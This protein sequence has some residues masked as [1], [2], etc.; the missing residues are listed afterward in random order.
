MPI[1]NHPITI[2]LTRGDSIAFPNPSWTVGVNGS[3]WTNNIGAG[4]Y[5]LSSFA[6]IPNILIDPKAFADPTNSNPEIGVSYENIG[7]YASGGVFVKL[8]GSAR[9]YQMDG[10]S[11]AKTFSVLTQLGVFQQYNRGLCGGTGPGFN[12]ILHGQNDGFDPLVPPGA[13]YQP[14]P[15]PG[16]T[17]FEYS[18]VTGNSD[19]GFSRDFYKQG[20]SYVLFN[21]ND[22][23]QTAASRNNY[24]GFT[25]GT[26]TSV[27][28]SLSGWRK[29]FPLTFIG[30]F[31]E[32]QLIG[33]DQRGTTVG[34]ELFI[35][36]LSGFDWNSVAGLTVGALCSI[37]QIGYGQTLYGYF[38]GGTANRPTAAPNTLTTPFAP[39]ES[40]TFTG[41]TT[42]SYGTSAARFLVNTANSI[43][44]KNGAAAFAPSKIVFNT[45]QN[46]QRAYDTSPN[47]PWTI[48]SGTSVT[49]R[50]F[51]H[52]AD[53]NKNLFCADYGNGTN[54]RMLPLQAGVSSTNQNIKPN[55]Y[56]R[57]TASSGTASIN[58]GTYQVINTYYG[59]PG[60]IAS[61]R[62]IQPTAPSSPAAKYE[63]LE[64]SRGITIDSFGLGGLAANTN[65]TNE[66]KV[67]GPVLHIKYT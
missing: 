20:S 44:F 62:N 50:T 35:D 43:P 58:L 53:G 45:A 36:G 48:T 28:N 11:G 64:L 67:I 26:Q 47:G 34:A 57:F 23:L 49:I 63:T 4:R 41:I 6:S 10:I 32:N 52:F 38:E 16:Q 25:A 46:A 27:S 12:L 55:D 31:D 51:N 66:A 42:G 54:V 29:S 21:S 13:T 56:V 2:R 40:Y 18:S 8:P 33:I 39:L 7:T 37:N 15:A 24:F 14:S 61:T 59:I 19:A 5:P 17:Y 1:Y 65:I 30:R 22:N 9:N 60:D 3:A